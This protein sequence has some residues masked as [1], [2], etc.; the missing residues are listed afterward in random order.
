M[1]AAQ[2][3][4]NL[5]GV[6]QE[7]ARQG[8]SRFLAGLPAEERQAY[9]NRDRV[10]VSRL[11]VSS[12]ARGFYDSDPTTLRGVAV[13]SSIVALILLLVCANVA[14]LLLARAAAREREIAVRLAIGGARLRIVRQLLTESV[15]LALA[16]GGAGLL[17]A[18][19]G[20]RLLPGA[21]AE[22]P[23]DWRV[24]LFSATVALATGVAFG[25]A[26]ALRVTRDASDGLRDR[27]ATAAAGRTLLSRM[28]LVT[29]I[30]IT[31]VLLVGAGLFL[32]TVQNLRHVDVGFNPE[33]LVLFR[34]NPQ[35]NGYDQARIGS[36]FDE[37]AR[38]LQGLPGVQAVT[39]SNPPLLSG[40]VNTTSFV[41]EGQ[42]TVDRQRDR[43]HRVRVGA[44]FF[45]ALGI[46]LLRGRGFT[47]RDTLAAPRVAVINEAAARAFYGGDDPIGRRFGN[48]PETSSTF[49]IVGIARDA[50]YNTL[51]EPAP[52]TMYVPYIQ[53]PLGGVAFVVRT[54]SDPIRVMPAVREAMRQVDS[55]LPLQDLSTQ[56]DQIERRFAQEQVFARAYVL[57]GALALL[58]AAIGLFGLMSYTVTRRTPEIGIR[59]A[60]GAARHTVLRMILRE[61]LLLV[62]VGVLIGIATSAAAARLVASLLFGIQPYDPLTGVAAVSIIAGVAA[63]AGYLP[64]RRASR[65]DPMLA[66]RHE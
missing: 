48:S 2:V 45:E 40:S 61:S 65:V 21:A 33:N 58:V 10:D 11:E 53:S 38:R 57:F 24:L 37:A 62:T 34:L 31:L 44:S 16:G 30:A 23:I 22:G 66:L 43:V 54:A 28:L 32:R 15:L 51:R 19:W 14:N 55:T 6:F 47:D 27:S 12:A 41:R 52:P 26:P 17:V 29:Q 25:I 8:M 39:M 63:L 20:R 49:E 35:L 50:K 3:E 7:A 60:L 13:I 64:A 4:G 18:F 56:T 59:M 36:L 46:P 5:Q 1:T 9:Q 42:S